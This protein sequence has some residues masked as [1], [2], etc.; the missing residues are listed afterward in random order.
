MNPSINIPTKKMGWV[1]RE[2][3][4]VASYSFPTPTYIFS[5][6]SK[7]AGAKTLAVATELSGRAP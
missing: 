1:K 7:Q 3:R 5:P 2:T 6:K 4:A